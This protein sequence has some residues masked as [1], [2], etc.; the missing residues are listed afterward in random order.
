MVEWNTETPRGI[1]ASGRDG[2]TGWCVVVVVWCG[3]T[4]IGILGTVVVV[5]LV[6]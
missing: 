5:V 2:M 3:R 6:V 1:A 4:V